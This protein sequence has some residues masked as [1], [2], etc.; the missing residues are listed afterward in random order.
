MNLFQALPYLSA[1]AALLTLWRVAVDPDAIATRVLRVVAVGLLA[2]F[3]FGRGTAP[4]TLSAALV[5]SAVAHLIPPRIDPQWRTGSDFAAVL[6]AML[7]G[8]LFFKDGP[9]L[10]SLHEAARWPLILLGAGV[11]AALLAF[12]FGLRRRSDVEAHHRPPDFE[13]GGL[14]LMAL[15]AAT[16]RF[17]HWPAMAGALAY[18]AAQ[19]A[20]GLAAQRGATPRWLPPAW[21]ALSFAGEAAIAWPFLR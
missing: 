9:G 2:A 4:S 6:A 14:A 11:A 15:T 16:L 7:F 5:L 10:Q 18:I 13:A 12:G 1:V 19:T 8:F 17:D 21:W 3:A 20:A